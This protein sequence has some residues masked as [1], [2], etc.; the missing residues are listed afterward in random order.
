MTPSH[1]NRTNIPADVKGTE[2]RKLIRA[3]LIITKMAA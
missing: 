2:E 1:V 3:M